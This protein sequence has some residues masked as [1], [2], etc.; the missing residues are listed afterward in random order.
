M[1]FGRCA[2]LGVLGIY[3]TPSSGLCKMLFA[4]CVVPDGIEAA[5]SKD[6]SLG[7]ARRGAT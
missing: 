1:V 5:D 6:L 7:H 3:V 2:P 4:Y